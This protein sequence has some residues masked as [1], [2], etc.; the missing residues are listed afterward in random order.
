MKTVWGEQLQPDA[1]LQE[2]PRPQLVR[3]SYENL[4]GY[5]NYAITKNEMRPVQW[6]G[7]ILVPFSP[8]TELSGV[9]RSLQPGEFLWYGRALAVK[10]MEA[11]QRLLLHIGACD[12]RAKLFC[13]GQYVME[14]IGGYTAFMADLTAFVRP[15]E[16]ELMV[17][18]RDDLERSQLSRGKQ[19]SHRGGIW[20]TPQSGIWQ[21]VWCEWVPENYVK[22]IRY[23]PD[24]ITNPLYW[25]IQV[26]AP[27]GALLKLSLDGEPVCESRA[28]EKGFGKCEIP[29]ELLRLWSPESPALYDVEVTLGE[30]HVTSYAAMRSFGV[31]EDADGTPRLLLNGKPYYQHGVLDQG[32]WPDGLYTA[33]SD[34]AMVSDI[35]LMKDFGFNMLRKHIKIEPMRWYY[36]C[37]RLGM[38]VWQDM[39]NGGGKYNL[40]TV[41]APLL[42]GIHRKDNDYRKFA[43]TDAMARASYYTELTEMIAQLYNCPCIC[44]WVAFNEG[45]G[46]FDAARAAEYIQKLDPTRVVDH[47]SG[48]H[49]QKIGKLQSLH[50]YFKPYHFRP[51]KLGRVVALTEF[52]GYKLAVPEHV[53]SE[54]QFGYKGFRDEEAFAAA[55]QKLYARQIIPA[56][57]KGLSASVY[58]QLS[59]VEDELNGLVTYDRK[60][61]KLSKALAREIAL[62]LRQDR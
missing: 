27:G 57:A 48:W 3:G 44:T 58:T 45:W 29:T 56:K 43:R 8:E 5:W 24:L 22:A 17:Q 28:D 31:G 51:D 37:D 32:Y 47:A 35:Q 49:D 14:H 33:P 9:G 4:N 10:R 61:V 15:G 30:D 21:T 38:L 39:I 7:K 16:N 20:Y 12:Q 52:G 53:W 13:N 6:D 60:H 26:K 23:T 54:K 18:V 1:V 34:A 62:S 42:T 36:H 25:K 41:S 40:L 55:F 50:V 11:G 59:D 19:S 2:Y 46:Q